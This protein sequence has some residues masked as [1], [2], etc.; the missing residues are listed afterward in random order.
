MNPLKCIALAAVFLGVGI[1]I[2]CFLPAQVL[3]VIAAAAII[4][5]GCYYLRC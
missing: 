2:T 5:I 4:I 3:V 1:L